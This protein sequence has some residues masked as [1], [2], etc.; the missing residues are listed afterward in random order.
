MNPDLAMQRALDR[1]NRVGFSAL[2]ESEKTLACIWS[3]ES[4]VANGGLAHFYK[5]SAGD[6][7]SYM[8]TAFRAV[9]ALTRLEIAERANAV[10][11]PS[12]VPENRTQRQEKLSALPKESLRIFDDLERRYYDAT[13]E[14]DERLE[15][16]VNKCGLK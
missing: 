1:L 4:K 16:Y 9:G 15:E 14:L 3:F 7:A 10:F 8:P 6:F 5:S 11:G 13:K 2:T 12:G